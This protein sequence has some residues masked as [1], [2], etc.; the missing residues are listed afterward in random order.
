M[1]LGIAKKIVQEAQLMNFRNVSLTGGEPLLYPH[2]E[3][4]IDYLSKSRSMTYSVMTNGLDIQPLIK[5]I[6]RYRSRFTLLGISMDDLPDSDGTIRD[7]SL[8]PRYAHVFQLCREND[9]PFQLKVCVSK[10]YMYRADEYIEMAEKNG[11]AGIEFSTIMPSKKALENDLMMSMEDRMT[12]MVRITQLSQK[13][14]Y[15]IFFAQ[16]LYMPTPIACGRQRMREFC[17][18]INGNLV[19]CTCL[20]DYFQSAPELVVGNITET[21]LR[22][23][24]VGYHL[25]QHKYLEKRMARY[26][27]YARQNRLFDYHTCVYCYEHFLPSHMVR[28]GGA[29][30][31]D[32]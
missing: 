18:D 1:P 4:F 9:I 13:K 23:L 8:L 15:P 27:E 12:L 28:P 14:S 6:Q 22:E 32:Q 21:A 25:Q 16:E 3:A 10:R 30:P 17:F 24:I 19:F 26:D 5:I 2:L 29:A 7:R 20:S 11:A 31:K